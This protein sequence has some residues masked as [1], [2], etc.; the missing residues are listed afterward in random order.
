M[1]FDSQQ[2]LMPHLTSGERILWADKPKPGLA[3]QGGDIFAIPFSIFW[4]GFACFWMWGAYQSGAPIFFM[5]FGLPFVAIG[6]YMLV[7]R[8]FFDAYQ[9]ARTV[10]GL[11]E[12][13]IMIVTGSSGQSVKSLNL[14][15]LP[16]I[17]I[18]T[19][20]DGSGTI[21]LGSVGGVSSRM[22]LTSMPGAKSK[23][24]PMLER[25]E[26]ARD[27][28]NQILRAQQDLRD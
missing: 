25:I 10:Y 28:Y 12:E 27:V 24:P 7:G 18:S 26:N 1:D 19:K 4:T 8:F 11:T 17:S 13:R 14:R 16:D 2:K 22:A 3:L 15:T 21:S 20:A 6:M 23:L 9:R 5:L